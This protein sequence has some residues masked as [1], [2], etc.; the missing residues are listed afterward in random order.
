[1]VNGETKVK[2]CGELARTFLSIMGVMTLIGAPLWKFMLAPMLVTSVST[3]MAT[4]LD[5]K[6]N[7]TVSAK[8]APV[9]TGLKAIIQGNINSLRERIDILVYKRDFQRDTWSDMDRDELFR[10]SNELALQ[11]S[12]L[13]EI[14]RAER[15]NN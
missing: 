8:I 4:E 3:A 7:E 10:L 1:M 5:D 2:Y 14:R 12:A 15:N 11:Q 13:D 9:T 6:I